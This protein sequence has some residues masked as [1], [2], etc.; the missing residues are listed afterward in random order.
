LEENGEVM[1]EMRGETL[2]EVDRFNAP[3]GKEVVVQ[4][5]SYENGFHMLRL[6]IREGKRFTIMDIDPVTA[7][8]WGQLMRQW[9]EV[10]LAEEDK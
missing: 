10:Q 4:E 2:T 3:Y 8:H 6:R 1:T 9:S 7:R 5:V